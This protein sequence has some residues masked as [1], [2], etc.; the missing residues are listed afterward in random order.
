[1]QLY[2][3]VIIAPPTGAVAPEHELYLSYKLGPLIEDFGQIVIPTG[4]IEVTR[5]PRNGEAAIGRVTKM[6]TEMLQGQQL[7]AYD[8]AAAVVFGTASP[9]MDG[10][11]GKVRWTLNEPVL[12]T[13]QDYVVVDISRR[14]GITTG[15]R[16]EFYQPRQRPTESRSLAL[17]EV[18]IAY[19]QVLRVTPFGATAIILSQE[20][21][22]VT[23]G[24]AAR[25]SAKMP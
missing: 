19:G 4:L 5:A 7:I 13:M 12:T 2:D 3:R 14:D 21:P 18:F 11:A 9:V 24:T 10:R 23:D 16:I 25:I 17:P 1:M 6:F 20:Q 8:S 22:K 15:D